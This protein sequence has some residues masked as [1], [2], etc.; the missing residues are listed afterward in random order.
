MPLHNTKNQSTLLPL[1]NESVTSAAMLRHTIGVVKQILLKINP[2]QPV[3]LTAD[4][5][6]YALGKEVQR[7]YPDLYGESN[8][9]MMMG[10]L[11]IEM[12]FF[13][14]IGDWHKGS[15][16]VE[17]LAKAD[18][19]TLG[20]AE[21]FLSGKQVKRSRYAHQVSCSALYLLVS[22]AYTRS[23]SGLSFDSWLLQRSKES[24]QFQYWATVMNL[25]LILLLLVKSNRESNFQ[26]FVSVLENIYVQWP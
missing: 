10:A 6:V 24:V 18:V 25:E 17:L 16:W 9:V 23:E 11:H 12:V 14:T 21:L 1:L 2:E 5:P 19:N 4:Q 3:G 20:R 7:M 13:N 22:D 26:L 15:A 8:T